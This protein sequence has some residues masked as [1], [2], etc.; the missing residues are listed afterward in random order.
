MLNDLNLVTAVQDT[1]SFDPTLQDHL[2]DVWSDIRLDRQA[3]SESF[4]KELLVAFVRF[5]D[6]T[7]VGEPGSGANID[8]GAARRADRKT[9]YRRT[10]AVDDNQAHRILEIELQYRQ[11]IHQVNETYSALV[12]RTPETSSVAPWGPTAVLNA[13]SVVLDRIEFPIHQKVRLVLYGKF[14]TDVLRHLDE[15]Y[16]AFRDGLNEYTLQNG[17]PGELPADAKG[18]TPLLLGEMAPSQKGIGDAVGYSSKKITPSAGAETRNTLERAAPV[19]SPQ[20]ENG[21]ERPW[22]RRFVHVLAFLLLTTLLGTAAWRFGTQLAERRLGSV[23]Q[24]KNLQQNEMPGRGEASTLPESASPS[25]DVEPTPSDNA[26]PRLA[27]QE[28]AQPPMVS[29][30]RA[31]SEVMRAV[32]L[33][34]YHWTLEPMEKAMLFNFLIRNG[35]ARRISGVEVVCLQYS[36]DLELLEPLKAVLP[37]TIEPNSSK[38]FTNIPAG[39]ANERVDRV[40][41]IIPDLNLE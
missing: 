2:A 28:S 13:F 1:E 14:I 39:F 22:F 18:V 27:L 9:G 20:E 5:L 41:C 16:L 21:T 23:T 10:F 31:K 32:E 37:E 26:A 11:I 30:P 17:A 29:D 12:G 4:G 15:A 19:D 8:E 38:N 33:V 6:Q 25:A 36:K 34:D 24:N 35:S 40:S 7:N 3:L